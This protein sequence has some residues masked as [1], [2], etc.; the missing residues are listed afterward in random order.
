MQL[1]EVCHT[2]WFNR[3]A[4]PSPVGPAPMT[5]TSTELKSISMGIHAAKD[6][7]T[8]WSALPMFNTKSVN[9]RVLK[10]SLLYKI[11]CAG[12]ERIGN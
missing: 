1:L 8:N 5:K 12:S 6:G 7:K 9:L 3:F 4:A 2:I 11:A 10:R